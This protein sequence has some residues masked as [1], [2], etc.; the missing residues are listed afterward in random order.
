[1][2]LCDPREIP[3][4]PGENGELR[5]DSFRERGDPGKALAAKEPLTVVFT[6]KKGEVGL[7]NIYAGV[8]IVEM[9]SRY[10]AVRNTQR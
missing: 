10:G 4:S 7:M 5:D 3:R 2:F 9:N 6:T 8:T 1:M